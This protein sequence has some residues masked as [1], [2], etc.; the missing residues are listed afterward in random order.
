MASAVISVCNS[1]RS[2]KATRTIKGRFGK[3][4][5]KKKAEEEKKKKKSEL[6]RRFTQNCWHSFFL[7][8]KSKYE[9]SQILMNTRFF[10]IR[11][12]FTL[13]RCFARQLPNTLEDYWDQEAGCPRSAGDNSLAGCVKRRLSIPK[14]W[15]LPSEGVVRFYWQDPW[16]RHFHNTDCS[17][18]IPPTEEH[19]S[20]LLRWE[21]LCFLGEERNI[22]LLFGLIIILSCKMLWLSMRMQ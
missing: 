18:S 9:Y 8:S 1:A 12:W 10:I 17:S 13:R 15:D 20:A 14:G 21:T 4:H 22:T 5:H 19:S 16:D 11:R 2:V 6:N 7:L 3:I